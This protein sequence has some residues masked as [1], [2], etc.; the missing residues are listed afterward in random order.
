MSAVVDQ[1]SRPVAGA[2]VVV[3]SDYDH[4]ATT[5][6]EGRFAV[7]DA[8]IDA[9]WFLVQAP[10]YID[11]IPLGGRELK[12][13]R[14]DLRVALYDGKADEYRL[15]VRA[16]GYIEGELFLGKVAAKQNV[17]GLIIKLRREG[18]G[19]DDDHIRL[20]GTVTRDGRRV[21]F[22][23]VGAWWQRNEFDR[24][25]AGVQRG[26]TVPAPRYEM[27]H[28]PVRPDGTYAIDDLKLHLGNPGRGFLVFE[29]PGHA[30]AVFGLP[31]LEAGERQ[32]T[33]DLAAAEGGSIAGRVEHVPE[34]MAGQVWVVAFNENIV[35]RE[36]RAGRDGAFRIDGLPPGRYGVK[37]GHDAYRDPHISEERAQ[38]PKKAE[39]WQGAA[40]ATVRRG[41]TSSGLLL[42]FRPPGP[43]DGPITPIT[44]L[45][46]EPLTPGVVL[47]E[48][49]RPVHQIRSKGSGVALAQRALPVAEVG[50]EAGLGT[51]WLGRPRRFAA[52]CRSCSASSSADGC[53][54]IHS[55]PSSNL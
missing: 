40:L 52:S 2:T 50:S 1:D 31:A 35:R 37:V 12:G 46:S 25:N 30:P 44:E 10:G 17:S 20:V 32:R 51:P 47:D 23:R 22:G 45:Q 7:R 53:L 54:V 9:F 24:G 14:T 41:A 18:R 39:P 43:L 11:P 15:G 29:E 16:E 48:S 5:D 13:Q 26:R 19:A 49:R 8:A 33:I 3:D 28:V 42:D 4:G 55:T 38:R 34:A 6:A 27:L 36:V 21:P